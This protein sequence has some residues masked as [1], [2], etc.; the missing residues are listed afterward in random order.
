MGAMGHGIDFGEELAANHRQIR[1]AATIPTDAACLGQTLRRHVQLLRRHVLP[2]VTNGVPGGA[3]VAGSDEVVLSRIERELGEGSVAKRPSE[4]VRGRRGRREVQQPSALLDL[5]EVQLDWED[6]VLL[7]L[8]EAE[9]T[10]IV[11]EDLADHAR[12]ARQR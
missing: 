3:Q 12:L 10:W 4:H 8:L 6:R 5:V 2:A 9:A 1:S 7:P 11:L